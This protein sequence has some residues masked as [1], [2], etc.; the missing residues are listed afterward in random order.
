MTYGAFTYALVEQVR[1]M[2][3]AGMPFAALVE[4]VRKSLRQRHFTQVP[5]AVGPQEV[6]SQRLVPW[7][8]LS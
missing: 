7:A 2:R 1:R 4:K 3:A 6:V 5:E 8:L